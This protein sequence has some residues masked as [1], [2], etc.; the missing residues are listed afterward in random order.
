MCQAIFPA[1]LSGCPHTGWAPN[2]YLSP[3]P[4]E[5]NGAE[6]KLLQYANKPLTLNW[7]ANSALFTKDII[8][9]LL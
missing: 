2:Q 1:K 3:D 6:V 8:F 5:Q 7:N 4:V 9:M